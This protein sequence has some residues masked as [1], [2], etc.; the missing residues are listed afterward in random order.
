[1][2]LGSPVVSVPTLW[3]GVVVAKQP[4]QEQKFLQSLLVPSLAKSKHWKENLKDVITEQGLDEEKTLAQTDQNTSCEGLY[5]KV[6]E[7]DFCVGRFKYIRQ[8]FTQT[9]L[10]SGVHWSKRPIVPNRLKEGQNIYAP[11]IDKS[12]PVPQ[13]V[14]PNKNKKFFV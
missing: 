9:I 3:Q 2:L 7:G 11:H 4:N 13:M 6:E 10:D 8:S 1:M 5:G 14:V 12:W